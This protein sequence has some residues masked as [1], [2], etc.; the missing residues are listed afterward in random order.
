MDIVFYA[1]ATGIFIIF[2][3]FGITSYI[4][5]EQRATL[6]SWLIAG[7]GGGVLLLLTELNFEIK[8]VILI[9]LGIGVLVILSLAF[10][11]IGRINWRNDIPG[12]RFDERDI[13]FARARLVPG[14]PNYEAYYKM[15]PENRKVDESTGKSIF[16][17]LA[18]G[19]LHTDRSNGG[20]G[21]WKT[22]GQEAHPAH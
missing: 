10:L 5:R 17:R 19:Q 6:I 12:N 4:E 15:R 1:L 13:M 2:S 18:R 11:P 22:S 16:V 20:Y 7:V 9:G 8:S 21:G 3:T 14:S